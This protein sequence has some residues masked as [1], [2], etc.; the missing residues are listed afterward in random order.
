MVV[1][2]VVAEAEAVEAAGRSFSFKK[3][4][5]KWSNFLF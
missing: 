2:P 3:V 5:P 4:A 1:R